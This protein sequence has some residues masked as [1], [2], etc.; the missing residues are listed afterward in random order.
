MRLDTE[1]R[2]HL[3]AQLLNLGVREPL[4]L[5]APAPEF[6]L[7]RRLRQC[8]SGGQQAVRVE[9]KLL[10]RTLIEIAVPIRRVV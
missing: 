9:Q 6:A 2:L 8:H 7:G 1:P 3:A 4:T 10:R 5:V